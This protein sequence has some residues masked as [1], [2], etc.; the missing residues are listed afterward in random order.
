MWMRS[1][2]KVYQ[3][4]SAE[5]IWKLWTDINNWP[6]WNADLEYC[7]FDQPFKVGSVFTLKPKGAPAAQISLV[8]IEHEKLFTDCTKFLGAKMY[9][10][11]EMHV[12]ENGLRLT[13]TVTVTGFLKHLW[14]KLVAQ[15]I[16]D[17]SVL[18]MDTLVQLAFIQKG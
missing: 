10:K 16:V 4:I 14:I 18:Q 5:Q 12:E 2:S 9:G 15:K 3:N 8:E 11:H 6:S 1:H 17:K 13:T 7:K